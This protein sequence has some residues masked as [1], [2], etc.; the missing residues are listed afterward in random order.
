MTPA[1]LLDLLALALGACLLSTLA[2]PWWRPE[3]IVLAILAVVSLRLLLRPA[4]VP[5]WRPRRV[6]AIGVV[7]YAALFSF[8]TVTRHFTFLTHAL[9]LGYYVQ[10]VW[11]LAGGRG[12]R[13]S[14]PEMH[15]WGDH[16]SPIMY[17]FVPAFR[18]A[19]GAVALLVAQSV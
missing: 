4:A 2:L 12:P 13:V 9:D 3:E 11:N 17:L 14:L 8:V 15:A 10:L 5:S 1:R 16:F 19:P 7:A 18:V 6:V